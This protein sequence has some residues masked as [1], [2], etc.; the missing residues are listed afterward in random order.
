M[1][2]RLARLL[3]KRCGFQA[4]FV[5]FGKH[6]KP[7]GRDKLYMLIFDV[8]DDDTG[9]YITDHMWMPLYP[10]DP[11]ARM[12][13]V[14]GAAIRFT[15]KVNMYFKGTRRHRYIDYGLIHPRDVERV[16]IERE[17]EA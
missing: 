5:K 11:V 10:D 8:R 12:R 16:E 3:G 4:V 15:A 7:G 17:M 9:R 14:E 6:T 1:R 2:R 13:L